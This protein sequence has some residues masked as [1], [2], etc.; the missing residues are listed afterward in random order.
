MGTW[1]SGAWENDSAADW[2]GD[3]FDATGLA[4]YVEETLNGDTE[5]FH[6]EIRAA[7]Y[8]LVSL[9]KTFIWPIDD[10]DNHLALAISKL[11]QIKEL[12]VY[13][14]APDVIDQIGAEIAVLKSRL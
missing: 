4:K 9:G 10:L 13:Q 5:E 11:E 3:M 14:S 7:A 6:E 1:D 12:E 2:F 8:I